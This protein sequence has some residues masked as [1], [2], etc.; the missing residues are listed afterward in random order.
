[1]LPSF[2]LIYL[3]SF[4]F[5]LLSSGK[6]KVFSGRHPAGSYSGCFHLLLASLLHS[7]HGSF[8]FFFKIMVAAKSTLV[9]ANSL[10][11]RWS[12][13][14]FLFFR[15]WPTATPTP[16]FNLL[17][18]VIFIIYLYKSKIGGSL[19]R[20]LPHPLQGPFHNGGLHHLVRNLIGKAKFGV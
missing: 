14:F 2:F 4:I 11:C 15:W 12:P 5:H 18:I 7:L 19:L 8:F 17:F 9:D 16:Q 3:L 6:I 13:T 10:Y 1:M 20:H